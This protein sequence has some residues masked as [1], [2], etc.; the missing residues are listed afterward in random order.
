LARARANQVDSTPYIVINKP[1]E[2]EIL[3]LNQLENQQR[4]ISNSV[5]EYSYDNPIPIETTPLLP[6]T[7]CVP[8]VLA[9]SYVSNSGSALFP[10]TPPSP[11][12][13]GKL[14]GAISQ[15]RKLKQKEVW[16][17]FSTTLVSSIP[18][19]T[20]GLLL[21]I[22]DGVSCKTFSCYFFFKLNGSLFYLDG[23]II[24]PASSIFAGFGSLGVSM[25]F[26]T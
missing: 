15:T 23:M 19:V 25:F 4:S 17:D 20:I 9:P 21:N 22:L 14:R 13:G 12:I 10:D 24:F 2:D 5:R 3:D 1:S 16:K 7:S 26:L 8:A 18:A 6:S 11:T